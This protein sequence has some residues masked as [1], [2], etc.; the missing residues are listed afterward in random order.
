MTRWI[1]LT[2]LFMTGCAIFSAGRSPHT[3]FASADVLRSLDE[4]GLSRNDECTLNNPSQLATLQAFFPEMLTRR[5]STLHAAW[6]PWIIVRFRSAD[7]SETYVE[8]DYRIYHTGDG[9]RGDFVVKDGLV[10][11]VNSLPLH[12]KPKVK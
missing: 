5:E 1:S 9:S 12:P 3:D 8:S 4:A 10:D 6:Y 11:F 7:G 2:L